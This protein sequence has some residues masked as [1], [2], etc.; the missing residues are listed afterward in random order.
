[1][2][3]ILVTEEKLK[4]CI[5]PTYCNRHLILEARKQLKQVYFNFTASMR[6]DF[7]AVL[8]KKMMEEAY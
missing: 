4:V 8:E 6:F 3:T 2:N 5:N 1:M 7:F